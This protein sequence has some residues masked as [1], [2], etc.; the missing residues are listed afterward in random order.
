[1]SLFY[2]CVNIL[3]FFQVSLLLY[4]VLTEVYK[5]NLVSHT[6]WSWKREKHF[7]LFA[8]NIG[9]FS[10]WKLKP[11]ILF[12]VLWDIKI[13]WSILQFEWIFYLYVIFRYHA[14]IIGKTLV[15]SYADFQMIKHFIIQHENNTYLFLLLPAKWSNRVQIYSSTQNN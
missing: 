6:M 11:Y 13:N 8:D 15:C 3:Y 1:M 7:I 12:F 4:V 2:T 10:L 9:C 5:W 14:L